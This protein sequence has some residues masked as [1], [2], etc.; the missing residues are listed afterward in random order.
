MSTINIRL[1]LSGRFG[2]GMQANCCH[3]PTSSAN[4]SRTV[5]ATLRPVPARLRSSE[6]ENSCTPSTIHLPI[7]NLLLTRQGLGEGGRKNCVKIWVHS[8]IV[9]CT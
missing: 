7:P 2:L 3:F 9:A 1:C 5:V 8:T 4:T 6:T